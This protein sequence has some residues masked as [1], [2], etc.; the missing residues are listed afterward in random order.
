[1]TVE[2]YDS[3]RNY[4]APAGAS[5]VYYGGPLLDTPKVYGVF[6]EGFPF[7]AQ[8]SA[9]LD[10]LVT[11]D[12]LHN[13]SEYGVSG[14][15][16]HP[17]DAVLPLSGP[18]PP[19]PSGGCPCPPGCVPA[20]G[21]LHVKDTLSRLRKKS[22]ASTVVQDSDLQ[23]LLAQAISTGG[24]PEPDVNSLYMLFLPSGVT[25]DMGSDASC[26][27]FCGYHNTFSLTSGQPVYYAVLPYPDCDGCS[28]GLAA[29][30]ALTATTTHEFAEAVTDPVPGTGWYDQA[31]GEV[32]DIC[33]WQFR[34]DGQYNVQLLWSN[35][36]RTCI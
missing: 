9:F 24:L 7:Q 15:G 10:W 34:Q 36:Q 8:M 21:S 1:V 6:I 29:F 27:T 12:V 23:N 19:P 20:P 33:A 30:D 26:Q 14:I 17:A 32:G 35:V 18:T 16:T 22:F 28:A 13:L 3:H 31:N 5:L 11:S 4:T 2:L 25:V